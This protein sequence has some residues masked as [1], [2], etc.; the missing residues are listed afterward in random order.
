MEVPMTLRGIGLIAFLAAI[1]VAPVASVPAVAQNKAAA[2]PR[3]PD[4]KPDLQGIWSYATIT[5]VERPAE[6][7]GKEFLTEQE[8]AAY[9]KRILQENN[10]DRRDGTAQEDVGRAYNDF[11]WDRGTK[12]VSTRRTSLVVDPPDGRIPPLTDEA[13]KR[14]AARTEERR[15]SGRGPSDGPED[16]PLGER[17]IIFGSGGVPMLPTAYNNNVQLVQSTDQVALVNEMIHDARIVP[18][19]GRP[20][21]PK[22]I[23]QYRGDSRGHWEGDTLVVDV[24]S[25]NDRTWL[26]YG[27]THHTDKMQITERLTRTGPTTISYEAVITDP[28]VFTKPWTVRS[29]FALRP[30]ERIREYEC[31]ENNLEIIKFQELLKKPELFVDPTRLQPRQ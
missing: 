13:R 16:R 6:F 18:L 9:E 29:G 1:A 2:A 7:A 4:G 11:W 14:T 21:L 22:N 17:C 10:R 25:F 31:G 12:V 30:N 19:D 28:G 8:A 15:R 20:P 27:A 23:R 24:R 3:T 26:G 5:P